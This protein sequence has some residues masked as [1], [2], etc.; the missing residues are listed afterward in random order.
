MQAGRILSRQI[1]Q[2]LN[3]VR[4]IKFSS[5]KLEQKQCQKVSIRFCFTLF[6]SSFAR[7]FEP[8]LRAL[9]AFAVNNAMVT[10][11]IKI[12]RT[13]NNRPK[14]NFGVLSP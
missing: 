2:I 13:P 9:V 8:I 6:P 12:H 11:P 14:T 10:K 3:C 7:A 4:F 5:E 1:K